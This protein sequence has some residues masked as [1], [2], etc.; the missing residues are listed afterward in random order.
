MVKSTPDN[1]TVAITLTIKGKISKLSTHVYELNINFHI[2]RIARAEIRII[3]GDVAEQKFEL[4]ETNSFDIGDD[5]TINILG[6]PDTK[7]EVFKGIVSGIS[8][9]MSNNRS[10]LVIHCADK[11][12]GLTK[13][14]KTQIFQKKKDSDIIKTVINEVSG[15]SVKVDST[16]VQHEKLLQYGIS[17]WDFAIMRAEANGLLV[18]NAN[19][20]IDVLTP[21]LSGSAKATYSLGKDVLNYENHTQ[22]DHIISD[23]AATHWDY[24]TGDIKTL[25]SSS[26]DKP[27][28]PTAITY[29]K[30][31]DAFKAP[32]EIGISTPGMYEEKDFKDL[33]NGKVMRSVLATQLGSVSVVGNIDADLGDIIEVKGL[34]K[35]GGKFYCS[36]INQL[37]SQ[38]Q[39]ITEYRFGLDH[40]THFELNPDIQ[41]DSQL[42]YIGTA[43]GIQLGEV[44][45]LDG[46]PENQMRIQVKLPVFGK[47]AKVW[48][49]LT[50]P[51]AG[52]NR[53]I[54]FVPEK[55]D[56]VVVSF[57]GG[58]PS[59][60]V[61]L[62]TLY[63][64]SNIS[65]EKITAD[66]D[67]R[68]IMSK[69]KVFIEFDDAK[70]NLLLK[71]PSG[72]TITM[73]DSK[74]ITMKDKNGNMLELGSAGI[75]LKTMK[76]V[77]LKA[78]K[79]V[80]ITA[81]AGP[82]KIAGL[83][84]EGNAKTTLK[85]AGK[86]TAEISASG[87]LTVKGAMVKIN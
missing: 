31:K 75:T 63:N 49:R 71:T 64:K 29:A 66:N 20:K 82:V 48:A 17:N 79:G 11:A 54:F 77:S 44:I 81:D 61:I 15:L 21:K 56:E 23:Y 59:Q 84:I 28:N 1:Q 55:G 60:P 73:D 4:F 2:N 36:G 80:K 78:T 69:K 39:W 87:I 65:P 18:Y 32:K 45:K 74:G 68:V 19:N 6:S 5:I 35:L 41:N 52:K 85:L 37:L 42:S 43:L 22:S 40:R 62:G 70:K 67:K 8:A 50:F 51:D 38:G 83:Q 25:K 27:L 46:D 33:I 47:E 58:D 76:E 24:K 14:R 9:E 10:F 30:L 72:N 12:L 13:G 7:K 57:L 3:D 16:T 34:G 86:A 53:G 26:S